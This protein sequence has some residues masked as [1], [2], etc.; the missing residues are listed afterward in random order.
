MINKSEKSRLQNVAALVE[1]EGSLEI[2]EKLEKAKFEEAIQILKDDYMFM[3][4]F[5]DV[6]YFKNANTKQYVKIERNSSN[7]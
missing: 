7:G 4:V 1:F 5:E 3:H 2:L 6:L